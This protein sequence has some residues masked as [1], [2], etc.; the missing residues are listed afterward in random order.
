MSSLRAKSFP[1]FRRFLGL[2]P[3]E[4]EAFLQR[5][6]TEICDANIKSYQKQ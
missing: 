6:E 4:I 3:D 5:F 2:A 1:K